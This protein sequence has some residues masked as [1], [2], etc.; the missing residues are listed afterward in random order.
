M[1]QPIE[2]TMRD[3]FFL[4][5][6]ATNCLPHDRKEMVF[7][8]LC[9]EM[10]RRV[11][12]ELIREAMQEYGFTKHEHCKNCNETVLSWNFEENG[13]HVLCDQCQEECD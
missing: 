6:C 13:D 5:G 12:E 11:S 7:Q 8:W 4:V 2:M 3:L 10:E 1:D 9:Y